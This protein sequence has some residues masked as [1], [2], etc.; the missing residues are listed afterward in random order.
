MKTTNVLLLFLILTSISLL[1]QGCYTQLATTEEAEEYYPSEYSEPLADAPDS[2][3]EDV[4][5]PYNYDYPRYRYWVGFGYYSPS[6]GVGWGYDPYYSDF[7]Y[8]PWYYPYRSN[9]FGSYYSPY[10][11]PYYGYWNPYSYYNRYPVI[12]YGDGRIS[13]TRESGSRRSGYTRG[14]ELFGRTGAGTSSSVTL[15]SG[16]RTAGGRNAGYTAPAP[17]SRKAEGEAGRGVTRGTSNSGSRSR[18]AS[19]E[20]RAPS[21]RSSTPAARPAPSSGGSNRSGTSSDGSRSSGGSRGRNNISNFP[22]FPRETYRVDPG[23]IRRV[24]PGPGVPSAIPSRSSFR[25]SYDVA[26]SSNSGYS[27]SGSSGYLAPRSSSPAPSASPAPS[28]GGGSSNSG[29]SRSSGASRNR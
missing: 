10:H 29:G 20:K 11:S 2:T 22:T 19:V 6:W 8:D 25:P 27:N 28:S 12:V 4:E 16:S 26:P 23:S 18:E 21:G 24:D 14:D 7:Y 13:R 9:Y 15:P 17:S 1:A 3:Y 5:E